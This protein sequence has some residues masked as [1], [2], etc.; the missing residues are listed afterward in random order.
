ME[1]N[2]N[3]DEGHRYMRRR[4]IVILDVGGEKFIALK[5]TLAR[6]PTTRLGKLVRAQSVRFPVLWTQSWYGQLWYFSKILEY[7][8]E[9]FP[10]ETLE[11]F[12]DKNPENFTSILDIYRTGTGRLHFFNLIWYG[13]FRA[14]YN[15][16]RLCFS[17]RKRSRVL[18]YWPIF[19]RSEINAA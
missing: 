6:L 2:V 17:V 5:R 9:F 15:R 16:I 14:P 10:G 4:S 19:S 18:E 12:F 3:Q 7:C 8:D 13:F 11:Y 1:G